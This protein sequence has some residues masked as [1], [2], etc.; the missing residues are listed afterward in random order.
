[1]ASLAIL[2]WQAY[3]PVLKSEF[4]SVNFPPRLGEMPKSKALRS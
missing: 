4:H 2:V 1:M 3:S